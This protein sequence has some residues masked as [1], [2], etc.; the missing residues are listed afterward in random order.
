LHQIRPS[1]P[2][3]AAKTADD[4]ADLSTAANDGKARQNA[5]KTIRN[6]TFTHPKALVD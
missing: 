5:S 6:K 1:Q 3:T 2:D 4:M